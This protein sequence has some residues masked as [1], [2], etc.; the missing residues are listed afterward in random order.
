MDVKIIEG[1]DNL[2][3]DNDLGKEDIQELINEA[4]ANGSTR[5]SKM[6]IL[7]PGEKGEFVVTTLRKRCMTLIR[8]RTRDISSLIDEACGCGACLDQRIGN[9]ERFVV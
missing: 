6:K 9:I 3:K 8:Y 1:M 7:P 4:A 5:K 2:L